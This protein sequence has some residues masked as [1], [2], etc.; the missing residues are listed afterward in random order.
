MRK[1][2]YKGCTFFASFESRGAKHYRMQYNKKGLHAS[3]FIKW[4]N[5]KELS[6]GECAVINCGVIKP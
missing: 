6:I 2:K 1:N 3:A 5:E 4:V